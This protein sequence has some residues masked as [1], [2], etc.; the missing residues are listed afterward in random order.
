MGLG[1]A[2]VVGDEVK[3]WWACRCSMVKL[4]CGG[5]EVGV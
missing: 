5:G 4:G 3:R 2:L 1:W